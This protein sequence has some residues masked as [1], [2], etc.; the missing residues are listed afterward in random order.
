MASLLGAMAIGITAL[1]S[2]GAALLAGWLC[3]RGLFRVLAS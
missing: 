3:L 2:L 1:L